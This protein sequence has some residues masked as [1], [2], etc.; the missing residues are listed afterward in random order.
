[1]P[2][3]REEDPP[4]LNYMHR[5]RVALDRE[6]GGPDPLFTARDVVVLRVEDTGPG[7]P[8][9]HLDRVFDPFFTTKDGR[10]GTGLG[11]SVARGIVEDHGGR[12]EIDG[13]RPGAG[14]GTCFRVTLPVDA[15]GGTTRG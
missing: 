3:R 7:I 11:L 8:E 4:G 6:A 10:R 2:P 5:R 13:S 15:T 1:M 14:G 9:E 12:I